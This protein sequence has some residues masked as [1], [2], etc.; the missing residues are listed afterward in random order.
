MIA[1]LL[2]LLNR[3]LAVITQ[4]MNRKQQQQRKVDDAKIRKDPASMWKSEFGV[5]DSNRP[6]SSPRPDSKNPPK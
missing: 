6:S 4:V 2:K 3:L 5:P 1:E